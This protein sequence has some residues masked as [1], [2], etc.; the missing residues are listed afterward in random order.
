M[1]LA[2][3]SWDEAQAYLAREDRL[4]FPIGAHEQHGRHLGLGC[5]F[6]IAEVIAQRTGE[7]TNLAVAPTF[8]YGMSLHHMQFPGTLSLKPATLIHAL[9]DIFRTAHTHGFRRIL[10]VNGH[11]GNTASIESALA[12][13]ANERQGLRVKN[14]EWWKEPEI[15]RMVDDTV[16]VQRGTHSSPGETAFYLAARPQAVK[17][18]R[19]PKRDAPVTCTREFQSAKIFAEK[20][21]DGVMGL[22]PS[23]ATAELGQRLLARSVEICVNE[24]EDW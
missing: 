11:G 20:Y 4:I 19:A 14:Y 15:L 8:A 7:R 12:V 17:M 22:E 2:D 23:P 24:I 10:I 16:G 5:D 9:E 6:H 18:A 3:M 21:P 13:V 1:L